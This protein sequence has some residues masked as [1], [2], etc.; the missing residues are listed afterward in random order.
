MLLDTGSGWQTAEA[1][2]DGSYLVF[3]ARGNDFRAAM[4]PVEENGSLWIGVSAGGGALVVLIGAL[5]W[6]SR[7]KKASEP[8]R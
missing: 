2:E 3:T 6:R 8:T 4:E 1:R 7:K 5:I